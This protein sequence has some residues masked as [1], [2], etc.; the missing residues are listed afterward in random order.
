[1]FERDEEG[2]M[3]CRGWF[4]DCKNVIQ[5]LE[6]IRNKR[7]K[8]ENFELT[9]QTNTDETTL[10]AYFIKIGETDY[11]KIRLIYE[12]EKVTSKIDPLSYS[13][14][15]RQFLDKR[16][17]IDEQHGFAYLKNNKELFRII[18]DDDTAKISK[19][20]V[21]LFGKGGSYEKIERL[22]A[23]KSELTPAEIS[24][25]REQI[26]SLKDEKERKEL[27][28]VLQE[29]VPYH[30]QR[31]NNAII[32]ED[33]EDKADIKNEKGEIIGNLSEE[34]KKQIVN[35]HTC[36][37]SRQRIDATDNQCGVCIP[38]ILRKISL[39]CNNF[40]EYDVEY[41]IGY[42]VPLSDSEHFYPEYKSTLE[43][44]ILMKKLIDEDKIFTYLN[45]KKLYYNKIH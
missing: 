23:S 2:M 16:G 1:M 41:D 7:V 15:N 26:A 27:Y 34:F 39:A 33:D 31:N 43:Y 18:V 40:E 25:V 11:K 14:Y 42:S 12:P 6:E 22:F 3:R 10:D 29:K 30:N 35:T 9:G 19:L 28:L 45:L 24:D 20:R 36:G 13:V 38:C 8:Q 37:K 44:F 32:S 4:D 5:M 17:K 21:Y